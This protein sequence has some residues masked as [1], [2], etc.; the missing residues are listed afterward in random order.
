MIIIINDSTPGSAPLVQKI[1]LENF[2]PCA[3]I[4]TSELVDMLPA[5]I[6][7]GEKMSASVADAMCEFSGVEFN[8]IRGFHSG[9]SPAEI[10]DDIYDLLHEKGVNLNTIS[11]D[12]FTYEA[13]EVYFCDRSLYLTKREALIVR[14][15]FIADRWLSNDEIARYCWPVNKRPSAGA[16]SVHIHNINSKAE[17][18][19]GINLIQHK[20][21]RGYMI[22]KQ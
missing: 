5:A 16:V 9:I 17:R 14:L 19:C 3:L 15:L 4:G 6:V 20:R 7:V 18:Y 8:V 11:D 2:V 22:N 13:G 12:R 21:F 1:F 10:A